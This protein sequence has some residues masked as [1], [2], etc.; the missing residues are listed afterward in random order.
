MIKGIKEKVFTEVNKNTLILL[1]GTVL[2]QALP[3]LFSPVL[4]RLYTPAEFGAFSLFFGIVAIAGNIAAG[5]LDFALY[6]AG[7]KGNA[8]TTALTGILFTLIFSSIVFVACLFYLGIADIG[9]LPI[10]SI[11]CIP[12]TVLS[13]GCS[14]VLVAL[15]NREKKFKHISRAKILLGAIWV[16]I[17]I[18]FGFLDLGAMG[19]IFGYC[20]GQL[21]SCGYL[22]LINR[23]DFYLVRYT[24]KTFKFNVLRNKNYAF[25]FLPAHLLNTASASGPAFFLSYFFSLNANG[26]FFKSAR[27][28]ESPTSVI[29]SSLGNVFWQKASHDYITTGN[30]RSTMV[31]FFLKLCVVGLPSYIIL[32]LYAGELFTFLFGAPWAEAAVYFKILVPYYFFQ[33]VITPVTIMIVLANK[34]WIDITWQIFYAISIILS[35]GYGWFRNDVLIGLQAYVI[36]MSLMQII[37]LIINYHYSI[38]R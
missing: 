33:F 17:N 8:I 11:F 3:L 25:I 9:K 29:R 1:Y 35:F 16:L 20:I 22:L 28:G 24:R 31:Q 23:Q 32:Y 18:I 30:A 37:S 5:K 21:V 14:N 27:V 36:S 7:S 34:P 4:A 6:T 12:V 19:L 13:L 26:F 10:A 15:S 38:K 2:S